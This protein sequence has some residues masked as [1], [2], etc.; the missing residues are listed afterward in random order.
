M[1]RPTQLYGVVARPSSRCSTGWR[2]GLP[3]VG[4]EPTEELEVVPDRGELEHLIRSSGRRAR[5]TRGRSNS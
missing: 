1:A 4:V 5:S 2:L 3:D